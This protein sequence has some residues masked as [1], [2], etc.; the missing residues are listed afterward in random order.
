[1]NLQ[2][3]SKQHF[4]EALRQAG[5]PCTYLTLMKW[6]KKGIISKPEHMQKM[7]G[8]TWRFYTVSEILENIKRIKE[9]KKIKI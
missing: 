3:L 6:E 7:N 5:L 4:L 8:Y 1:M 9:Y 2:L